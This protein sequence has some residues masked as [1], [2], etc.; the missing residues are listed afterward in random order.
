[1]KQGKYNLIKAPV[2]FPNK[3]KRKYVA[4]HHVIYWK[5]YGIAPK[6]GEVIHHINNNGRDNNIKNLLLLSAKDHNILH[7][8][9]RK[10]DKV[11]I[12]CIGCKKICFISHKNYR[13]NKKRNKYGF[14]CNLKCSGKYVYLHS[15][16]QKKIKLVHGTR[17]G[18][19]KEIRRK[20]TPCDI[21]KRANAYY[22]KNLK[23][24]LIRSKVIEAQKQE[25]VWKQQKT[26]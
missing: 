13:N 3:T 19:L 6:K 1:M 11:K 24:D 4:D 26:K 16:N 7:S 20:V 2:G 21:C 8:K 18:Y 25:K 12:K 10:K 22:T 17:A 23:L 15:N 14:F 9:E 5:H